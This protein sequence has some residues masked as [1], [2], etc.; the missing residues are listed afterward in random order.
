[1]NFETTGYRKFD[2]AVCAN[3]ISI[4][5]RGG[6]SSHL[7]DSLDRFDFQLEITCFLVG[8]SESHRFDLF[9]IKRL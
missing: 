1:L 5:F 6:G 2:Q 8:Q 4:P 7:L 3:N 9:Q